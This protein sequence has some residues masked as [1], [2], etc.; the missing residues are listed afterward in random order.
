VEPVSHRGFKI[1]AVAAAAALPLIATP[2]LAS[3]APAL[4]SQS[5]VHAMASPAGAGSS[6]SPA[7]GS[8]RVMLI[9]GDIVTV[10]TPAGGRQAA[11]VVRA[12][13]HGPG[14]QFRTFSR[15][16]DLYVVPQSAVP[17][18]GSTLSPALFDVTALARQQHGPGAHDRRAAAALPGGRGDGTRH[19]REPPVQADGPGNTQSGL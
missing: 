19:H 7:G 8:R 2:A 12:A 13:S 9:T 3:P 16:A 5:Q 11:S 15:G 10:S 14:A 17:Y 18:L 4:A 6:V 1:T